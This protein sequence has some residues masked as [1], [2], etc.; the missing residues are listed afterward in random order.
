MISIIAAMAKNRIIGA[1]GTLPWSIPQDMEYFRKVTDGGTI[2]MGRRTFESI[3]K[4]LPGRL[5]IV[6]SGSRSFCGEYLMTARSLEQALDLARAYSRKQESF[7]QVFLCGG[8]EIYR[9]GLNIA[10]RIYLTEIDAE[11]EGDVFFPELPDKFSLI[12]SQRCEEAGLSFN[13]YEKTN[14]P[15][16]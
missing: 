9:Q 2:I 12:S 15:E 3:G 7:S 16:N 13:I 6:I 4:A 11:F 10:D 1:N 14:T 5:N 8:A